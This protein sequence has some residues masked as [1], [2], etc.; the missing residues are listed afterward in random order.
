MGS[1]SSNE[2]SALRKASLAALAAGE[3][4]S[5]KAILRGRWWCQKRSICPGKEVRGLITHLRI[6]HTRRGKMLHGIGVW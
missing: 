4:G 1:S 3:I 5:K 2:F 6:C